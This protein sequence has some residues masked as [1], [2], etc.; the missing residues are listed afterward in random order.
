MYSATE[1]RMIHF[2]QVQALLGHP[3]SA[4]SRVRPLRR[5]HDRGCGPGRGIASRGMKTISLRR[6][7]NTIRLRLPDDTYDA[8]K[9]YAA[10]NR[11]PM[12]SWIEALLNAEHTR[13]STSAGGELSV[14]RV[15]VGV[16]P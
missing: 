4:S 7:M 15:S 12:S 2:H 16:L 3:Q 13:R 9:K 14:R 5:L 6:G 1:D 10:E 8:V 11:I